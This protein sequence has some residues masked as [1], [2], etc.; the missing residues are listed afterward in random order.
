MG[1]CSS[2]PDKKTR[3]QNRVKKMV[4]AICACDTYGCAH[5]AE[6]KMHAYVIENHPLSETPPGLTTKAVKCF[7]K[8][9]PASKRITDGAPEAAKMERH[10]KTMCACRDQTCAE[11]THKAMMA[12]VTEHFSGEQRKGTTAAV[13]RWKASQKK[14]N[15]CYAR[16]MKQTG[17]VP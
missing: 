6:R 9:A 7:N 3:I 15:G 13:S 4:D 16:A 2:E 14:F 11:R 10:A 8:V 5:K 1:G 17:H 12:W